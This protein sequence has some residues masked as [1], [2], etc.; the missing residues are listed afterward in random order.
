MR[1]IDRVARAI[2][3][4]TGPEGSNATHGNFDILLP[5]LQDDIRNWAR[6]AIEAMREPTDEMDDAGEAM[7]D[8]CDHLSAMNAWHAMIDAALAP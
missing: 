8:Q 4:A 1:M 2:Y 5:E 6:A 7:R 3:A